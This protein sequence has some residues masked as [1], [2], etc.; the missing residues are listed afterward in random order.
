MARVVMSL[1]GEQI[2]AARALIRFEQADLAKA[3]Q[4]SL[5]TIKR[6][7]RVRGPVAANL[8]TITAILDV[9]AQQNVFFE[10]RENGVLSVSY[11]PQEQ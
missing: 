11:C 6:L 4:L 7:E 10:I 2:R 9:F 3:C 5:D 8:R 1:R